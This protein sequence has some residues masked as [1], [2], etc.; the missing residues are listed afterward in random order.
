MWGAGAMGGAVYS[1]VRLGRSGDAKTIRKLRKR[2]GVTDVPT[3][4]RTD[5][6]TYRVALHATKKYLN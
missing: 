3:D 5:G 4:R 6:V 1:H 2:A